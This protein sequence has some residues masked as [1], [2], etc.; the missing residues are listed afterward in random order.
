MDFVMN[1]NDNLVF[2]DVERLSKLKKKKSKC[3]DEDFIIPDFKDFNM[4]KNTLYNVKQLKIILKKYK[5]K[6]TGNK[7]ELVKRIFDFLHKSFFII[8]IQKNIRRK[9]VYLFF[10]NLGPGSKDINICTNKTDFYSLE[11]L[12][13]YNFYELMSIKDIDDNHIYGFSIQT[14]HQYIL[15]S[16]ETPLKN[17]YNRNVIKDNFKIKISKHLRF[18]KIFNI[19]LNISTHSEIIKRDINQRIIDIFHQIDQLGNYTNANWFLN[20]EHRKLIRFIFE[21][22]DIWVYRAN[23]SD[24]IKRNICS[25]TG[26]PFINVN[27]NMIRTIRY[28]NNLRSI[29]LTIMSNMI[30]LGTTDE[31][32]SLGAFYILTALTLVSEEAA[33][34]LPWLYDSVVIG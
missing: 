5:L 2:E 14:L 15:N 25:P 30:S 24:E 26:N 27:L 19:N 22:K 23:L 13:N 31:Y 10:N 6:Q 18:C 33:I 28:T 9:L 16:K 1:Y 11:E 21:L 7:N 4:F 17:P 3:L 29:C 34:A 8:K 12:N 32:K 20:L